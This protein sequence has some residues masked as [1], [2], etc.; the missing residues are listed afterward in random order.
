MGWLL[1]MLML[2]LFD[3]ESLFGVDG[4]AGLSIGINFWWGS[5][6]L[7]LGWMAGQ[8]IEDRPANRHRGVYVN[9]AMLNMVPAACWCL[10]PGP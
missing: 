2:G 1:G 7:V 6:L 4:V 5:G 8:S 9:W 10:R 3:R